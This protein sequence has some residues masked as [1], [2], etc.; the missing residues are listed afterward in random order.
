[1]KRS[2][3]EQAIKKAIAIQARIKSKYPYSKYGRAYLERGTAENIARFGE[4]F[5]SASA[6]QKALRK[7]MGY[8]GRGLY[9]GKGGYWMQKLFGAKPGGFLDSLGDAAA[10]VTSRFVPGYDMAL[11]GA[12]AIA[13]GM[14]EYTVS[15]Q[16]VSGAQNAFQVPS[17]TPGSDGASVC[18]SHKEYVG[19]IYAPS[20]TGAFVNQAYQI[21]PG[22]ENLFPWLSQVAV[23]YEEY[24]LKQCMF[25]FRSTVSD[26]N[27]GTGQC[28]QVI[29]ATQYNASLEPFSDKLTMMSYDSA[30]SSKTTEHQVHG[31]ECD[32]RKLS[33]SPGKYVRWQPLDQDQDIKEYDHAQFNIAIADIPAGFVNQSIGELW[34]SY[35]V[36][37]R[38]PKLVVNKALSIERDIAILLSNNQGT[39]P[40]PARDW[41]EP[42]LGLSTQAGFVKYGRNN[43]IGIEFSQSP[44]TYGPFNAIG[45]R[46]TFPAGY[47]G[48]LQIKI[49]AVFTNPIAALPIN[50]IGTF[51]NG[52]LT[53]IT[54]N[55]GYNVNSG[56]AQYQ[57]ADVTQIRQCSFGFTGFQTNSFVCLIHLDVK[58]VTN[59]VDN[60]MDCWI[61][62]GLD[63]GQNYQ[64]TEIDVMEYN[65]SF[66][67]KL[68]GSNNTL[69]LVD[70]NGNT[71]SFP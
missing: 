30:N 21:N 26:Y 25:T 17:F 2:R 14:G 51:L 37:L 49:H 39:M 29:M 69:K 38:K 43:S 32:P 36:E 50:T 23:N 67:Q 65:S 70:I 1:M 34:I 18:I 58:P 4:T 62:F 12:T 71:T 59:G 19:N 57:S 10:D 27:S 56:V 55:P 7:Q 31:V 33:G 68:D 15:N 42:L 54:D 6:E 28:G 61:D 16:L 48:T 8:T 53:F 44:N 64:F 20:A 52:N 9:R 66:R 22:L 24:D 46:L 45:Q 5:K 13:K 11:R 41:K 40:L 35:T 63:A 3:D 47:G 60:W